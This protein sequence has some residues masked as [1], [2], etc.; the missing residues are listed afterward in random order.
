MG[1]FLITPIN[2]PAA[3]SRA[4]EKMFHGDHYK[5]PRSSSLIVSFGGTTK[6]L[7]DNLGLS[8]GIDGMSGM[9][10]SIGNY[11]GRAPS[12]MWEWMDSRLERR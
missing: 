11:Y 2:D 6:E 4:V 12:D 3:V 10:V 1:L 9:V 8:E 7:S 5:V